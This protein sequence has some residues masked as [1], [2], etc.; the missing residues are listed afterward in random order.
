MTFR[1]P[2]NAFSNI[3]FVGLLPFAAVSTPGRLSESQLLRMAVYWPRLV[4]IW[5]PVLSAM[6][7]SEMSL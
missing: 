3:E 6:V 1:F 5:D 7:D 4:F 2:T